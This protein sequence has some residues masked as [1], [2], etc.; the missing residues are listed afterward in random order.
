MNNIYLCFLLAIFICS[1]NTDV[2]KEDSK[3]SKHALDSAYNVKIVRDS[4]FKVYSDSVQKVVSAKNTLAIKKLQPKMRFKKDE[5]TESAWVYHKSSPGYVNQN[6]LYCYFKMSADSPGPLRFVIQHYDDEW[7]F[8][9]YVQFV[10]D[11]ENFKLIP[12]HVDRDNGSGNIWEWF[13]K[14]ITDESLTI[15]K[16]LST[17]KS[18]KMK[19]IGTQ[20]YKI[21]SITQ[22]QIKAIKDVLDYYK[23]K[24]G[25]I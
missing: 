10:L 2:S 18:A 24:G 23:L 16:K 11:D 14:P 3:M 7:L 20:Y 19:L 22:S 1:C 4:L 17:A 12:S 13:D 25:T 6:A 15:V 5:F 9:K 8:I 21:K